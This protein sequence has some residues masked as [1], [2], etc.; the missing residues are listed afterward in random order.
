MTALAVGSTWPGKALELATLVSSYCGGGP[1][2]AVEAAVIQSDGT[3][4]LGV[5]VS[6]GS[7]FLKADGRAPRSGDPVGALVFLAKDGAELR[8]VYVLGE[9]INAL[10]VDGK[11]HLYVA[12]SKRGVLKLDPQGQREAVRL[13][14]EDNVKRLDVAPNGTAVF[15]ALSGRGAHIILLSP[16]GQKIGDFPGYAYTEDVGLDEARKRVFYTGF[17][18]ATAPDTK[19]PNRRFPVQIC[20]LRSVDFNGRMV[21]QAYNYPTDPKDPQYLNRPENNMADTRGYR[22]RMGAD[23]RLYAA[24]EA[25][26]GNHVFRYHPRDVTQPVHNRFAGGDAYHQFHNTRSE[27]KL[28]VGR[29]DPA[30]GD[31]ERYQQLTGRLSNG[32]GNAVRVKDGA[33]AADE[34]GQLFVGGTAASGLPLD[35]L[36]EG[37]GDYTG[38]AYIMALS[39]D[40]K[41]RY[42][43]RLVANGST[44]AV[45]VRRIGSREL[46][47]IGGDTGK[48]DAPLFIKNAVQDTPEAPGEQAGF[49][50]VFEVR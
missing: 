43:T 45:A 15:L 31:I 47:V 25:A 20:Y 42:V 41:K 12:V 17:R 9:R 18:Q 3:I 16:E 34:Q 32:R 36:P 37:T 22:C 48:G 49:F 7:K 26:G 4:V 28:V 11:D 50:A 38:G 21:W 35:F 39:P 5:N 6:K 14:G 44:R 2:N 13:S 33:V 30:T 19:D 8:R 27:H 24:F 1:E 29:F 10:A 23:G 46:L 40:M